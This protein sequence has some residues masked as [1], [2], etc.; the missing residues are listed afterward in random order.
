MIKILR[1]HI[2]SHFSL[3][4][5]VY[6]KEVLWKIERIMIFENCISDIKWSIKGAQ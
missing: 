4:Y 3:M 5:D 2:K 6:G 1:S